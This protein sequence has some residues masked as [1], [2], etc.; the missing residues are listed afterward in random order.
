M[1][2]ESNMGMALAT[3]RLGLVVC[4]PHRCM[5]GSS[6]LPDGLHLLTCRHNA[7]RFP[8]HAAIND[9]TKPALD[10]TSLHSIL[11]PVG[12][13]S[14]DGHRPDSITVFLCI[15]V[16]ALVWVAT[17]TD[18]FAPSNFFASATNPGSACIAADVR[19]RLKY[20]NLTLDYILVT[21]VVETLGLIGPVSFTR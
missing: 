14:G 6:V 21:V 5:C 2:F 20:A 7:G 18:T 10:A 8:R 13:D 15:Q 11:E 9:I 1:A 12:L 4:H 16:K 19:M 3:L 17:C